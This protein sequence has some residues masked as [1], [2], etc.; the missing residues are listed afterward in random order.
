MCGLIFGAICH[1]LLLKV[2]RG[3]RCGGRWGH[4]R[5]GG[6]GWGRWGGDEGGPW[7]FQRFFLRRL[8][9]RLQTTPGQ[10]RVISEAIGEVREALRNARGEFRSSREDIARAFSADAFSAESM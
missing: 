6:G 3:G 10:E 7:M 5:W 9:E 4:G 2:A 1:F 8:F